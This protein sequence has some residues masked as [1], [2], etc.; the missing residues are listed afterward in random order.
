MVAGPFVAS[1]DTMHWNRRSHSHSHVH[2]HIL[3]HSH[4]HVHALVHSHV[5]VH[6]HHRRFGG[7]RVGV[8]GMGV[9]S[10]GVLMVAGPFVASLGLLCRSKRGS[11]D[12][13][14][15]TQEETRYKNGRRS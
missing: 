5:H 4:V 2:A 6:V 1:L 12:N 7:R 15:Q 10:E 11:S 9:A 8:V 3:V 14:N 13:Q